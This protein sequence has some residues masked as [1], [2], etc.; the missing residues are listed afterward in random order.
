M[1]TGQTT[2]Y[3][4]SA[5]GY[6]NA[7]HYTR[8]VIVE[9]WNDETNSSSYTANLQIKTAYSGQWTPHGSI[10]VD[11]Y[12][13]VNSSIYVGGGGGSTWKTVAA[14]VSRTNVAHD[15][16]GNLSLKISISAASGY[17]KFAMTNNNTT[18]VNC[19]LPSGTYYIALHK[20][21]LSSEIT[22]IT[23]NI[24]TGSTFAMSVNR[25]NDNYW[26][27][28]KLS[29]GDTEL[30]VTEP[31]EGSTSFEVPRTWMEYDTTKASIEFNA[32]LITYTDGTCETEVGLPRDAVVTVTA[33]AEMKPLIVAD[34]SAENTAVSFTTKFV[35]GYSKLKASIAADT[36]NCA[37]ATIAGYSVTVEG[38]V[39][40]SENAELTSSNVFLIS[41]NSTVT[42]TATDTRGR[43]D[44]VQ[45]AV[46][47]YGYNIPGISI[48]ECVR[49]DSAGNPTEDGMCF[50]VTI[51]KA[52]STI[53]G[54][55]SAVATVGI[56]GHSYTLEDNTRTVVGTPGIFSPD[57]AY[58]ITARIVDLVGNSSS[59][60]KK[61]P[62]RIWAMHFKDGGDGVAFGKA[63]EKANALQIPSNWEFYKG[64]EVIHATDSEIRAALLP[65]S[66]AD[67]NLAVGDLG[68]IKLTYGTHYFNAD[69]PLPT[70]Q[71]GQLIFVKR[72]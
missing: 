65:L 43:S 19:A 3:H 61:I 44:S 31:F 71:E 18:S 27:K 50:A 64:E 36:G 5:N 21:L 51:A 38:T 58:E 6:S 33:D 63:C 4:P 37:G 9:D 54:D 59:Q 45:K 49:C 17:S 56:G 26:H 15:A 70:A 72:A 16:D 24:S 57:Q 39:T 67:L 68:M 62:T 41:G 29:Y 12:A 55:N 14:T 46:S 34:I 35:Q 13:L 8:I 2:Y 22:T 60:K 48:K 23:D 7:G 53:G 69:D 20:S 40:E 10:Y 28:L 30:L 1:A 66:G 47:V 52:Y 25:F 32:Q 42:I 11:G